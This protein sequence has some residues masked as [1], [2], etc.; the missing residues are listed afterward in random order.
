MDVAFSQDNHEADPGITDLKGVR[1]TIV[2][3][4]YIKH[5]T[6]TDMVGVRGSSPL[7]GTKAPIAAG[8]YDGSCGWFLNRPSFGSVALITHKIYHGSDLRCRVESRGMPWTKVRLAAS[9]TIAPID[10][11]QWRARFEE[12]ARRA[13]DQRRMTR[14]VARPS[15]GQHQE[16][17][18]LRGRS[19]R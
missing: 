1:T 7:V 17:G 19:W 9:I 5:R 10:N 4:G 11:D 3:V 15:H 6:L 12:E 13:G 16:T 14:H 8:S 18:D 2:T